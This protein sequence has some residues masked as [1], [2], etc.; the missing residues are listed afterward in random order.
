MRV[1]QCHVLFL[2]LVRNASK[3]DMDFSSYFT[4]VENFTFQY[5]AIGKLQANKVEKI[6][7]RKA[8]EIDRAV[9]TGSSSKHILKNV[10]RAL[11]TLVNDLRG[12]LPGPEVFKERFSEVGYRSSE[13]TRVF[14][15]YLL[16]TLNRFST[17]GELEVDFDVVNIEHI[18][19]QK[20]DEAWGLKKGEI[21]DYVNL[22]GNL[23]LVHEVINSK[24]GN[25][26]AKS[27]AA[28]LGISEIG[29]T[30]DV[31]RLLDSRGYVWDEIGIKERQEKLG[32]IAY[33]KVWIV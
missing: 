18:L 20:P 1:N 2:C 17:T 5:S 8:I 24:A 4:K 10:S 29:I 13:Q 21:K 11:D 9:T 23:T 12:L 6:Y 19:P 16:S 26:T 14:L 28:E 33:E 25:K 30:K 32:K 22:L 31:V 27:K 15:K 7:S 3:I